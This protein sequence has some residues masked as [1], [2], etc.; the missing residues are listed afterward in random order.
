MSSF[1]NSQFNYCTITLI[2]CNRKL[3]LKFKNFHKRA[4]KVVFN[5]Y[6]KNYYD[7]LADHDKVSIYQK[8]LQFLVT[9]VFKLTKKIV[10]KLPGTNTTKYGINSPS[11]KGAMLWNIMPKKKT[12]KD[13][14]RILIK[15][16]ESSFSQWKAKMTSPLPSYFKKN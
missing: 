4:L 3:K 6:E 13:P 11:F 7:F 14:T 12:F 9:E 16:F 5:E 2:F 10:V 15:V 1:V 8:H